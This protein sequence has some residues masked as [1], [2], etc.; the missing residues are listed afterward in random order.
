MREKIAIV[1]LFLVM[2]CISGCQSRQIDEE[3]IVT[4]GETSVQEMNAGEKETM[5]EE[6]QK[7]MEIGQMQDGE[8]TSEAE[9]GHSAGADDSSSAHGDIEDIEKIVADIR[10]TYDTIQNN[11]DSYEHYTNDQGMEGYMMNGQLYKVVVP[12]GAYDLED[13]ELERYVAEYY[14]K[15]CMP[16]FVFVYDGAEEHRYY[17]D[18]AKEQKC[19]RYIDETGM[20]HDYNEGKCE[21]ESPT[22]YFW[23]QAY[24]EPEFW[25]EGH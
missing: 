4:K 23:Y 24:R 9:S 5:S 12:A 21:V 18:N 22:S 19:I 3:K 14:Y 17:L 2:G 16:I 8:E 6:T 11:L 20:I 13:F 10:G 1:I 25:I 15:N 7:V